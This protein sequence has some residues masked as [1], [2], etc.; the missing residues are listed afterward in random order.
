MAQAKEAATN[1]AYGYLV[2]S[3]EQVICYML[4]F[5]DIMKCMTCSCSKERPCQIFHVG[6]FPGHRDCGT[7][8]ENRSIVPKVALTKDPLDHIRHMH[9]AEWKSHGKM[10]VRKLYTFMRQGN[11]APTT[12][13]ACRMA[14]K[15]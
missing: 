3:L 1:L 7:L 8:F 2:G 6:G 13:F 15:N 5:V 14:S 11:L 10:N 4:N 12:I 9:T